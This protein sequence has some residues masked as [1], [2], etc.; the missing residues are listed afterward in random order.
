V[1]VAPDTAFGTG[2]ALG[3]GTTII[4]TGSLAGTV[5]ADQTAP[6]A[7]SMSGFFT[8]TLRSVVVRR[9]DTS[10]LDFYFQIVN[11]TPSEAM[12]NDSEIYAF[13]IDDFGGYGFAGDALDMTYRTDGLAGLTGAG[14]FTNGT[15]AQLSAYR[16]PLAPGSAGFMFASSPIFFDDP[17]NLTLG[18]T[19][20]FAVIRTSAT[21]FEASNAL[22]LG[23]YG[24]GMPASYRPVPEPTAAGLVAIGTLGLCLRRRRATR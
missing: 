23:T 9:A 18:E 21:D 19:S 8:G 12:L 14:A 13:T 11:T 7:E 17:N 24:T 4:T 10:Q 3:A 16:E 20:Q 22:V 5:I 6:F 1:L 15:V 2:P